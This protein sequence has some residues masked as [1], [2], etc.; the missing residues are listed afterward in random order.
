MSDTQANIVIDNGSGCIKCGFSSEE[1]PKSIF[2][3]VISKDQTIVGDES[4]P[5]LIHPVEHGVIT[6][7]DE[8][9]K[10]WQHTFSN[11]LKVNSDERNVLISDPPI[12]PKINR[13]K[14]TQIMFEKFN[15]QGL[16]ISVQAMLSMYSVGKT[17]GLVVDSGDDVTNVVP[18]IEGYSFPYTITKSNFGGRAVTNYL[19]EL[20]AEKGLTFESYE[21]R[22][23][24]RE[25]KEKK[26][27][28]SLDYENKVNDPKINETKCKLPDGKEFKVGKEL[29]V[30]TESIFKP[31]LMRKEVPGIH[32]QIYNS[33]MKSEIEIRKDLYSNIILAGGNTLISSY[34]ERL[35]ME[36][37][38]L[39]PSSLISKIKVIAQSERKYSAWIGGAILAGLGNFQP[40]W[41]SHAEYQD[42][43]P[44]IIHRKCL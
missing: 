8:M 20:L 14:I 32:W 37:Q 11:E 31:E 26:C 10:I 2:P 23:S 15:V 21:N 16:F 41:I 4:L 34:P 12:A 29:F 3:N 18:I 30:C 35:T 7:W 44:Q 5:D 25:I 36:M 27:C 9:E 22:K 33:I 38:K 6:K 1:A 17:T 39:A 42:A 43:G 28:I 13:E 19:M 40:M 24:V